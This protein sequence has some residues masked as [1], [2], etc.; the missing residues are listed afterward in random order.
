[1]T[2]LELVGIAD[3]PPLYIDS[4]DKAVATFKTIQKVV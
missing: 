4:F 1:M 3:G 2:S